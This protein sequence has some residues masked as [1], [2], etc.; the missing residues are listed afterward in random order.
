MFH[1]RTE[2]VVVDKHFMKEKIEDGIICMPYILTSEQVA[3]LLTKG[4]PKKQ[5]ESLIVKLAVEDIFKPA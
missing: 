1:D 2:H 5:F 4:L 3:D